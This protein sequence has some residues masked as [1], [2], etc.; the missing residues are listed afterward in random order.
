MR[1][2]RA[3]HW[4]PFA[5]LM[6]ACRRDDVQTYRV[7]KEEPPAAAMAGLE[8]PASRA[9]GGPRWKA[10]G[11]WVEQPATAMR[12]G[13]FLVERG[14]GRADVSI[15]TLAGDAGGDLS[16]VNRWRDQLGLKPL[17]PDELAGALRPVAL[18]GKTYKVLD[19]VSA[20]PMLE[21]GRRKRTVAAILKRPDATWFFKMTG[22]DATVGAVR[23]EFERFLAGVRFEDAR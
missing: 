2:F 12:A 9:A 6:A 23:P 22:D 11:G 18:G 20:A 17:G 8:G 13:S 10:P 14:G 19:A 15:V 16:N 3:V 5:F 7:P 21:G 1:S 4:I